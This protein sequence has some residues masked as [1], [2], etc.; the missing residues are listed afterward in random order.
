MVV[1]KCKGERPRQ[2]RMAKRREEL[3]AEMVKWRERE[4]R[5]AGRV[6]MLGARVVTRYRYSYNMNI[7]VFLHLNYYCLGQF[8]FECALIGA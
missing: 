2:W 3:T 6:R 7:D 1:V 8:A 5:M 4:V